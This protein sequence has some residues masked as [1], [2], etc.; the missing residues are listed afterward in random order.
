MRCLT[1]RGEI[2]CSFQKVP[3]NNGH[4]LCRSI[5]SHD[6][7]SI[8]NRKLISASIQGS[9]R[10]RGAGKGTIS[11]TRSS[12]R[13]PTGKAIA[14][15]VANAIEYGVECV[16]NKVQKEIERMF[17]D[18]AIDENTCSFPVRCLGSMPL[19]EKVT[20]LLE[21]QGPLRK[22]YLQGVGSGVSILRFGRRCVRETVL[23]ASSS[24]SS[25]SRTMT[26][27]IID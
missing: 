18:V 14:L 6:R 2:S 13:L 11:S 16:N 12:N 26:T 21:L 15:P 1:T 27:V 22:L 19:C 5:L 20:S 25:S 23:F 4:F 10:A 24:S 9:V 7:H 3:R 8:R 17:T